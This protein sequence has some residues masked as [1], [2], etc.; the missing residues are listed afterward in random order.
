MVW[1]RGSGMMR[2]FV[3]DRDPKGV[4]HETFDAIF[5]TRLMTHQTVRSLEMNNMELR[6]II[7]FVEHDAS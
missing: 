2:I 4:S 6:R 3:E 1:K 7:T 5:Q